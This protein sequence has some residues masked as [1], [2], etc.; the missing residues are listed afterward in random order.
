MRHQNPSIVVS[1][2]FSDLLTLLA[3]VNFVI[4]V[5]KGL[6]NRTEKKIKK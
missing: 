6:L 3:V 4:R 2:S 5:F 1:A